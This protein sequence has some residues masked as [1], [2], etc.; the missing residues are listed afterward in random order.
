MPAKM[1]TLWIFSALSFTASF[2]LCFL[3]IRFHHLHS[4]GSRSDKRRH[5]ERPI[6]LLGGAA[7][8]CGFLLG[9]L[10]LYMAGLN[11]HTP[12]RM[13]FVFCGLAVGVVLGVLDDAHELRARWK[14]LGHNL[15][16][17]FLVIAV[18]GLDTPPDRLLGASSLA[19]Y[20]LKWFWCLGILNSINLIDGL[21]ELASGLGLL[22]LSF[23]ALAT[24]QDTPFQFASLYLAIPAILGFYVWNRFPARIYLG[25][26]GAL[27]IGVFIFIG[28]MGFKRSSPGNDTVA[29]FFVMGVPIL[30]T[31]LA[32]TRRF[33]RGT[34]L[35][36]A[37]R[38]H[39]HHRLG[40]LG[41]SHPN[42]S[43]FLHFLTLYLCGIAYCFVQMPELKP[44]PLVLALSGLGINLF[45]MRMAERKLYFY[46]SNFASHMLRT[47]D[48]GVSDTN[49]LRLR[50][51]ALG[52]SG[53][54]HIAFRLD[55][56]LCVGNLLEKSPGRIQTFYGKL[57]DA[58]RGLPHTRE[59]HFENSRTAVILQR[60]MPGQD[61]PARLAFELRADLERFEERERIDLGLYVSDSIRVLPQE[62]SGISAPAAVSSKSAI[63]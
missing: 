29:L 30:D 23:L 42:I 48:T 8:A 27:A 25:E 15:V 41:L 60:L 18:E 43:R 50:R 17:L 33:G 32:I 19:A 12:A 38:E 1:A 63:A 49:S 47:I 4:I 62:D 24:N 28:S 6:P 20:A 39:L 52:E 45:L 31:L 5:N 14:F 40:R 58:L 3:F 57:A 21:D 35:M 36:V 34:G 59:V 53:T 61:D 2:A 46:L 9:W 26:S 16:A 55:L 22:M 54:P 44:A 37:D 10:G 7:V 11:Q 13:L 51:Q 56:S